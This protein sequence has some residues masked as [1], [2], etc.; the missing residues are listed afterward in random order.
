MRYTTNMRQLENLLIL[1]INA[2]FL[3]R[4]RGIFIK[5]SLE[6]YFSFDCMVQRLKTT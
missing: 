1:S 2:K 4:K 6:N 3:S 5:K